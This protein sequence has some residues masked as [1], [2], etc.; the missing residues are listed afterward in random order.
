MTTPT[1]IR[2]ERRLGVVFG[3]IVLAFVVVL[4]RLAQLQF[5]RAESIEDAM[6]QALLQH[7]VLP[8]RR[9]AILDRHG[10][11]FAETETSY[12]LAI[13][14]AQF[15]ETNRIDALQ[16]L[17]IA[18]APDLL[19]PRPRSRPR[20]FRARVDERCRRFLAV[21]RAREVAV[22]RLMALRVSSLSFEREFLVERFQGYRHPEAELVL[23]P[24]KLRGRLE[25]A[26]ILLADNEVLSSTRT[27]R[28]RLTECRTLGEVLDS[29]P[30]RVLAGMDREWEE[31]ESM[32]HRVVP[33][34]P[35]L[36]FTRIFELEQ[37]NLR[38]ML[39]QVEKSL[40]DQICAVELGVHDLARGLSKEKLARLAEELRVGKNEL[41]SLEEACQ[42]IEEDAAQGQEEALERHRI[43]NR[44]MG[45]RS[46][47]KQLKSWE[48]EA[49]AEA[50]EVWDDQ[51]GRIKKAFAM[52]IKSAPDFAQRRFE[53]LSIEKEWQ[54]LLQYKGG[55]PY[56]AF[57][58]CDFPLAARVWRS[59]G[60]RD[61]GFTVSAA[62][63]RRYWAQRQG[64]A[65]QLI[66]RCNSKGI[67]LGGL[68]AKLGSVRRMKNA[69]VRG[70][71][72][73]ED[74]LVVRQQQ[75]DHSWRTLESG[76]EPVHG[77]D[78]WL[79]LD[80]ELQ[81]G[82]EELVADLMVKVGARGGA[83][84]CVIDV[85]TGEILV[86]ASAPR[87]S[88]LDYM[89]RY[90]RA[91]DLER[92]QRALKRAREEG[93]LSQTEYRGLLSRLRVEREQLAFFERS[94]SGGIVSQ[95]PPGSVMKPFAA[96]ALMQERLF[97]P[98]E[99]FPCPEKGPVNVW[100]A[101]EKSSNYFFWEGARR[102]GRK[103]LLHWLEG[104]GLLQPIENLV[105]EWDCEVRRR[106]VAASAEK[107]TVIGQGSMSLS[108][109]EVAGMMTNL[110]RRGRRIYPTVIHRIG[111]DEVVAQSGE[112]LAV[113][114]WIFDGIFSA[115]KKVAAHYIPR[116]T[117]ERLGLAGKTGTAELGGRWKGLYNAWFA[118]FAPA[119]NPRYAFAVVA[120]R[121][122]LLGKSTA[123]HA[124]R[125]VQLVLEA[126]E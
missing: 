114:D 47:L 93:E 108:V 62:Q 91:A 85:T 126:G 96:A 101:I 8:A 26:L 117:C 111:E 3:T 37:W 107:N 63:G 86:L 54:R 35:P 15:R 16:D 81:A 25:R 29:E 12:D 121:T 122:Q 1:P 110:A 57:R 55:V 13:L 23:P 2:S 98:D 109:L 17:L 38:R 94:V 51:P 27:L 83:A 31:L 4:L 68:E 14:P 70:P 120:E 7:E 22:R 119:D 87:F 11:P 103:R 102:L 44:I 64:V 77:R 69:M 95:S 84:A 58:G 20:S 71:L 9:G 53:Y 118:G 124:A 6:A 42:R 52:R 89:D 41:E 39:R 48:R 67:P 73:G 46:S 32:R 75:L 74:G 105:G 112:R 40:D 60:V 49:L 36:F 5:L 10:R 76:R 90:S 104:F 99:V 21:H 97:Q 24:S 33:N 34:N 66:G 82:A 45:E 72:L 79:T 78:V 43:V 92:E 125:L 56:V 61:L 19:P 65:A 116:D 106:A 113:D 18:W 100:L 28:L 115:M 123:G 30:E 59:F 88:G 80:R 50:L